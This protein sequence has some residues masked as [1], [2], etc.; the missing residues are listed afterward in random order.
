M[1]RIEV[2]IAAVLIAGAGAPIEAA[3]EVVP[4]P[5]VTTVAKVELDLEGEWLFQFEQ[6]E[7]Q[8]ELREQIFL[9]RVKQTVF[10]GFAGGCV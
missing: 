5:G 9:D 2:W 6:L 7:R 8:I 4:S 1:R 3:G 10:R